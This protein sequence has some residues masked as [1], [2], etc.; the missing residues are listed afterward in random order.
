MIRT[1]LAAPALLLALASPALAATGDADDAR[2]L[3]MR[4]VGFATVKGRGQVPAYAAF[5]KDYLVQAGFAADAITITPLADTAMLHL[6][7]KA[8]PA[9]TSSA[10]A[11]PMALTGHMD[12]VEANPKDW[13]RD[14]FT[15]VAEGGYIF[16]RGVMDNKFDL[17]MMVA[18]LARLKA[19]GFQPRRDIHLFLSGDEETDG[20]T[21]EPQA[22][23]AKAAGVAFML[24]SDAGGGALDDNGR[25]QGYELQAAEKTYADFTVTITNPGGHSSVP[26][27]PNA[28]AQLGA[29]AARIEAHDFKPMLNDI[30]RAAMLHAARAA[31]GP[32]G[33]AL[34]AFAANPADASA[35]AALRANPFTIGMIQTTCVPTMVSGGHAPNALPQRAELTVNC[36][37]FPGVAVADVQKELEQVAAEPAAKITTLLAWKATPPSP[38]TPDVMAAVTRAVKSRF[39]D[40]QP[41]PGMSAGATDSV[42]YRAQ[43]IPSYGTGGLWMRAA[44]SFAHG[45]DERVPEA[46]IAPAL[47]HWEVLLRDLAG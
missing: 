18:T 39:P 32:E 3:L 21:A 30:T 26:S 15:A 9:R 41:V 31:P 7:W 34:A 28:I 40:V 4:S 35:I 37:I 19:T 6:V 2:A 27:R 44:D 33:Q 8:P 29:V 17:A 46:A 24:N 14:P 23:E 16:G 38:L 20:L 22:A 25:P 43:G 1:L 45:L 47:K 42:F 13:R 36:R 11:P 5:L 10:K 12:V